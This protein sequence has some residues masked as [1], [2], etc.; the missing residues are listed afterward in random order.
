MRIVLS[1]S[2]LFWRILYLIFSLGVLFAASY[3]FAYW[4]LR[5]PL[6]GNDAANALTFITWIDKFWPNIPLWWPKQGS[7]SSF[8]L[9][10][11]NFYNYTVVFLSRFFHIDLVQ[12]MGLVNFSIIPLTAFGIYFF[13]WSRFQ[14]QT[15]ALIAGIFFLLSPIGYIHIYGAGFL[16]Y[17]FSYIFVAPSLAFYD[18]FLQR[19][20]DKGL[21]KWSLLLLLAGVVFSTLTMLAHPATGIGVLV[22]ITFYTFAVILFDIKKFG[23]LIVRRGI[24]AFFSFVLLFFLLVS[25]WFIPFWRYTSISNRGFNTLVADPATFP[26]IEFIPTFGFVDPAYPHYPFADLSVNMVVTV[27]AF[28]GLP[29]SV[30]ISKRA[31]AFSL[32]AIWNLILVGTFAVVLFLVK[33]SPLLSTFFSF[34]YVLPIAVILMPITA[35]FGAWGIGEILIGRPLGLLGKRVKIDIL[36]KTLRTVKIVAVAVVSIMI[37]FFGIYFFNS[38]QLFYSDPNIFYYGPSVQGINLKRPWVRDVGKPLKDR[39]GEH[40]RSLLCDYPAFVEKLDVTTFSFFC[41][42]HSSNPNRYWMCTGSVPPKGEPIEKKH[43]EEFLSKCVDRRNQSVMISDLCLARKKSLADYLNFD[44]WPQI[45][46]GKGPSGTTTQ[47]FG[48]PGGPL[49]SALGEKPDR[50]A[51]TPTLGTWVKEWGIYNDIP[52]TSLYTGQIQLA[53]PFNGYFQHSLF[54]K[55]DP[56]PSPAVLNELAKWYGLDAVVVVE[57]NDPVEK[58]DAA[59]WE[60]FGQ[61]TEIRVPRVRE[62]LVSLSQK[63]R[64]LVISSLEK[65]GY[66]QVF[67]V[68]NME[69]LLYDDVLIF[70]G[71]EKIDDYDLAELKNYDILIL[72]GYSYKNKNKAWNLLEKYL[73]DGGSLFIDTGWQ[74]TTPDWKL[75][76]TPSFLP[77]V[78]TSWTNAGKTADFVIVDDNFSKEVDVLGFSPLVWQDQPWSFSGAKQED[79]RGWAKPILKVEDNVLIAGGQLGAGRVMWSGMNIFSHVLDKKNNEESK[80]LANIFGF[81]LVGQAQDFDGFQIKR[82][83]PDKVEFLINSGIPKGTTLY[84]RESF[85]PNWQ[86]NL[87]KASGSSKK[88]EIL[89]TG[90]GFM[91]VFLPEDLTSGDKVIFEFKKSWFERL[92]VYISIFTLIGFF[93]FVVDRFFGGRLILRIVKPITFRKI[94]FFPKI[95]KTIA[96]SIPLRKISFFPRIQKTIKGWWEKEEYE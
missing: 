39:C 87:A 17:T 73:K 50:I 21:D 88:L 5:E 69:A 38:K 75:A 57:P 15:T 45:V 7:G 92:S 85:Y 47:I 84:F 37:V 53:K 80:F 26:P 35:A 43:V 2:I 86:A 76:K 41:D 56:L 64:V 60:K 71:R 30:L 91:S 90:P 3:F 81:L 1:F 52:I 10:H 82:D 6:S 58:Y 14:N 40:D 94:S 12:A 83:F 89:R 67:R 55:E 24:S 18:S 95:Q 32:L 23:W 9:G 59:G 65:N 20:K 93:V 66:E 13:V 22:V 46:L 28:A 27:F 51:I 68:S 74:F 16:N 63:P 42:K 62:S 78:K 77:V 29:L 25:F 48:A 36:G 8:I 54:I 11:P 70:E 44:N 31:F 72:H 19:T 34:R 61:G 49:I 33:F 96:R 4:F 79:L